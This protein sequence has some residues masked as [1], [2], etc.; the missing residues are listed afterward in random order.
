MIPFFS[1][2]IVNS[3]GSTLAANQKQNVI[4][5]VLLGRVRKIK[6]KSLVAL[7]LG[8]LQILVHQPE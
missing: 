6:K 2:C 3:L 8:T 4:G 5:T 1:A 7:W